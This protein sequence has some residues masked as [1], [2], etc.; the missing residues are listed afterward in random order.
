MRKLLVLLIV[1]CLLLPIVSVTYAAQEDVIQE[2][3]KTIP[4]VEGYKFNMT[5]DDVHDLLGLPDD[6]GEEFGMPYETYYYANY[7][8]V[9]GHLS[10]NYDDNQ[11]FSVCWES[12]EID[13]SKVREITSIVENY[14][15]EKIGVNNDQKSL[16]E[17]DDLVIYIWTDAFNK[18]DYSVQ[19]STKDKKTQITIT[20]SKSISPSDIAINAVTESLNESGMDMDEMIAA[21]K[22]SMN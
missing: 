5:P 8:D 18:T 6:K 10:F 12:P 1:A 9:D 4:P 21:I 3:D 20:M 2:E 22:D 16:T 15:D 11:I 17:N 19:I 7:Y 14:Y 13:E